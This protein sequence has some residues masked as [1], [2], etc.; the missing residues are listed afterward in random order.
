MVEFHYETNFR[1]ENEPYYA[2]WINRILNSEE[3]VVG[4]IDYVFCDDVYLLSINQKFLDHNT[5]TDIISFNYSKGHQVSGDIFISTERVM[6]NAIKYGVAFEKE[7]LRVM[8]HG[9]LHFMGY[10]DKLDDDIIVMRAKEE[11]KIKMFH[12][13]Q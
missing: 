5:Y 13:E 1:L 12:V 7:L 6:E 4:Q 11:E 3:K 10:N 8:T 2:D 9:L